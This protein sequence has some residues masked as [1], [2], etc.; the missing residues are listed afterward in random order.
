MLEMVRGVKIMIHKWFEIL[1]VDNDF[2]MIEK[3]KEK[4]E[5]LNPIIYEERKKADFDVNHI[6]SHEKCTLLHLAASIGYTKAVK[7]LI[8]NGASVNMVDDYGRTPLHLAAWSGHTEIAEILIE[9]GANVNAI[10]D[11]Y[12]S[13]PLHLAAK[14]GYTEI[15]RALIEKDA[16]VNAMDGKKLTPL[17]FAAKNGHKGVVD[18]LMDKGANPLLGNKN[19][20]LKYLAEL[21]ENDNLK[22]VKR[23]DRYESLKHSL[24]CHDSYSL[25]DIVGGDAFDD[26]MYR[27]LG[28]ISGLTLSQKELNKE[29]L[30]ILQ[31]CPSSSDEGDYNSNG[32]IMRLEKFLRDNKNNQDLEAVLNLRRGESKLTVLHA[33]SGIACVEKEYD[34]SV[35]LLLKAG[36]KHD[37]KD[38]G[39]RTPLHYATASGSIKSLLQ[40]GT[41][42]SI[43]DEQGKTPLDIAIDNHNYSVEEYLLTNEQ[44]RLQQELDDIL[45]DDDM[46]EDNL[47]SLNEGLVKLRE[48]LNKHKNTKDLKRVLNLH[49]NK[50]KS[51]IFQCIRNTFN[52][53]GICY[54][55]TEKLLLAAGAKDFK[56]LLS[57]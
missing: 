23:D 49:D 10:D 54:K 56:G 14:N 8:E 1:C 39:G 11:K 37:I 12:K 22:Q 35:D 40:A 31:S 43:C 41:D 29:L 42:L 38:D 50:G 20:T 21:T 47:S 45:Y 30:S 4:L 52:I 36:A 44:E 24:L 51:Q 18:A 17:Y 32:Y 5:V 27:W 16:N 55:K 13:T 46:D 19:K 28:D 48:F 7:A 25:V 2:D 57:C 33:I 15:V 26:L 34:N 6:V 9:K 53:D 3:I